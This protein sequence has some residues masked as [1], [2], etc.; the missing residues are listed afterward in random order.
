VLAVLLGL[1]LISTMG[2]QTRLQADS[3]YLPKQDAFLQ[4]MKWILADIYLFI[5]LA[6]LCLFIILMAIVKIAYPTVYDQVK[7]KVILLFSG[8]IF[9]MAFRWFYYLCLQFS[10]IGFNLENLISEVPFYVS[11]I[12]ISSAFIV[13]L[14]K[15]YDS[16]DEEE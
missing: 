14:L 1:L 10:W 13:F 3:G 2:Y 8:L 7:C 16:S 5:V 11:E 9:V 12:L 6:F 15:V 4:T